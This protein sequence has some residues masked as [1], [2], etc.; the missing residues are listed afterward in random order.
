MNYD[1][2][3]DVWVRQPIPLPPPEEGQLLR[4]IQMDIEKED[5]ASSRNLRIALFMCALYSLV[6]TLNIIHRGFALKDCFIF[7]M[8]A[9]YVTVMAIFR[10]RRRALDCGYGDSLIDRVVHAREVLLESRRFNLWAG[11]VFLP[12]CATYFALS[13][14]TI[15]RSDSWWPPLLAGSGAVLLFVA[16]FFN[17]A[18]R[19]H[20]KKQRQY[21][22][23]LEKIRASLMAGAEAE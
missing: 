19:R 4:R 14:S 18:I 20:R 9:S 12:S 23:E 21:L 3:Q 1:E 7:L 22:A 2:L 15:F 11:I 13:V 6:L 8:S 5:A 17:P 10:R 16:A